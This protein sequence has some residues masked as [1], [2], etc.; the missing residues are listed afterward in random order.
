[1]N[2]LY[3]SHTTYKGNVVISPS[4]EIIHISSLF[5]GSISDKE[6]VRQSGHHLM[7]DKGFVIQDL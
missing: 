4:R 6:L 1:M 2:S 7:A 3:N 5:E